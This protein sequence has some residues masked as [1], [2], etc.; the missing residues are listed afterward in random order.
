MARSA[1]NPAVRHRALAVESPAP[2]LEI[3]AGRRRFFGVALVSLA[4]VIATM[5]AVTVFHTRLA[6][7]Q[8]QLDVLDRQVATERERYDVLRRER[9]ELAAPERLSQRAWALGLIPGLKTEYLDVPAEVRAE[10]AAAT[11]GLDR[12][13]ADPLDSP[14]DAYRQVKETLWVGP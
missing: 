6:E 8:L 4:T 9:A 10:V 5:M 3:V 11:S 2:R 13:A 1:S 7:R 12:V 14:L